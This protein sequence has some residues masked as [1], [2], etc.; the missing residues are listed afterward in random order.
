[1]V[2]SAG[3]LVLGGLHGPSQPVLQAHIS[4]D[5]AQPT[6]FS[7]GP[8]EVNEAFLFSFHYDYGGA[9]AIA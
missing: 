1:M 5:S 4:Q 6:A 3:G 2:K 8:A 7:L 9:G